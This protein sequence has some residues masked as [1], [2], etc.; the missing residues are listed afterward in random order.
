[1]RS[2][3]NPLTDYSPEMESFELQGFATNMDEGV[4]SEAQEMELA[5]QLLELNSE[6]E[7]EQFLGDLISKAGKAIGSF[8]KSPIGNAIGGVLKSA[9]K[10]A[11]PIA[12]GALGTFVG[13]PMGT[14]IGSKLGSMADQALGPEL[15]GLSPEDRE[16]EAARQ[17]VRFAGDTVKNALQAPRSFD[18]AT[19]AR[20]AASEAAREYIPGLT[21]HSFGGEEAGHR[22]HHHH[23]HRSQWSRQNDTIVVFGV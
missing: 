22:Q 10:V 13:G 23:R 2:Y 15:E 7:L 18:P 14:A 11:L 8:V 9:A 21:D 20:A 17:F 6:Q 4:F 19:V 3:E 12:G 1:M 16:F 5:S